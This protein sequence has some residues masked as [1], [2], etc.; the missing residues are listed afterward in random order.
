M[1]NDH[2]RLFNQRLVEPIKRMNDDE[3]WNFLLENEERIKI[4]TDS[5]AEKRPHPAS[6][7]LYAYP[8]GIDWFKKN[9]LGHV[10]DYREGVVYTTVIDFCFRDEQVY[11]DYWARCG[12]LDDASSSDV[13]TSDEIMPPIDKDSE[14]GYYAE[15]FHLLKPHHVEL[16]V[17][18]MEKNFDR[19]EKNTREDIDQIKWMK[20][21]CLENEG[22]NVAYI[23]DI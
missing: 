8:H 4:F 11:L 23:Y 19:L 20:Q 22:W 1:E 21:F 5:K 2:L 17:E 14:E 16:I 7:F 6:G 12:F 13:K 15:Y 10:E 9:F 3:L 18:S